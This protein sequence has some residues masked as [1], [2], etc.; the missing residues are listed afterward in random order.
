MIISQD[1]AIHFKWL[2]YI[3][4]NSRS[5]TSNLRQYMLHFEHVHF[6]RFASVSRFIPVDTPMPCETVPSP[7]GGG[8]DDTRNSPPA[9]C[10]LNEPALSARR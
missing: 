10:A 6:Q 3:K 7:P 1:T 9:I 2:R 4:F 8:D 5:I